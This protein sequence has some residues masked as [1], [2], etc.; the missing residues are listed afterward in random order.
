MTEW[1]ERLFTDRAV[2]KFCPRILMTVLLTLFFTVAPLPVSAASEIGIAYLMLKK[3][4]RY[5]ER[6]TFARFLMQP[7]GRPLD[8]AHVAMGESKFVGNAIGVALKLEEVEAV[9]VKDML[10]RVDEL[11]ALGVRYFLIDA[12][13]EVV[14]EVASASRGK[15]LLL[16]NVTARED[17]L[18]QARC[19]PHLLH[20]IPNYAM[21]TDALVQYLVF[22]KWRQVLVLE[23]PRREDQDLVGAFK[24]SAKRYG[25]KIVDQRPFVLSNDPRERDQNN[26][27]LLTGGKD[28]DVVF[29]ADTDGEFARSVPYQTVFPR[30]VVGTEGLAG[31]A[32]HWSWD[33]HGAPQLEKRFEKRAKRAMTSLDWAAWLG[34]KA[35][36]EAMLRAETTEFGKV[37]DFL[38][39]EDIILDGFKGNRMNFRPWDRQLRQPLLIATHNW[40]VDRAP[41]KGFLHATNN[42]DTLGF[43]QR[44][45]QCRF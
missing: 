19:A 44:D 45:S 15:E 41:I 36:V 43:D 1:R 16:L 24:R 30:P 8:G 3:D 13:A 33:R 9:G 27:A 42:L 28:Y 14:A 31:L 11:L 29:V 25:A 23:G 7:L 6:R 17:D 26:V 34:V 32:W 21:L 2:I 40:V 35:V 12:P 5:A 37:R 4:K 18:R 10:S 20:V 22:R 38:L 39:G